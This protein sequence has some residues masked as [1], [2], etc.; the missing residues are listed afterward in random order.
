MKKKVVSQLKGVVTSCFV[1]QHQAANYGWK[2]T[3][4]LKRL[5]TLSCKKTKYCIKV[6]NKTTQCQNHV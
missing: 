5:K 4:E 2:E 3:K 6:A 1:Q